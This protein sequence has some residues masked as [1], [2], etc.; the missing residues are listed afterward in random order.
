MCSSDLDADH[1]GTPHFSDYRVM[2]EELGDSVDAVIVATPD[3]MHAPVSVAAM[4]RGKHV[5]CQKPIA[6]SVWEARRLA[7]VAAETKVQTQ[8]GNQAHAGEPIRRGVE[9]IRAGVIGRVTEVHAWTNRPIW[10]QGMTA[11]PKAETPPA[12]FDQDLFLGRAQER[13]YSNEIHPFKWR[14]Y[15]DYGCGALGDMACHIMDA[16]YWNLNQ[17]GR[18]HV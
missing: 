12:G 16:A 1:P 8:M 5:Y 4:Q 10:P 11:W 17:I 14:G 13:T 3:H 9:L 15:Q 7:E 2:L 18:A 6:H